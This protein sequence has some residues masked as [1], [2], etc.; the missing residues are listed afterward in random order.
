M[1]QFPRFPR[2][3]LYIQTSVTGVSAGRV[4][5][6]GDPRIN[7]RLTTPRGISQPATSFIGSWRQGIHHRP[8]VA[9]M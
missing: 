8:L 1:F 4:S 6:F 2:L 7:A 3:V 9:W 5:P